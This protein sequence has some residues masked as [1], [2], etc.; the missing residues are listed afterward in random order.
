MPAHSII[1]LFYE[2]M[3]IK[4]IFKF[5]ISIIVFS[6]MAAITPVDAMAGNAK[7]HHRVARPQPNGASAPK[8]RTKFV[9]NKRNFTS[10][11]YRDKSHKIV[12]SKLA[13]KPN[14][15]QIG[16]ESLHFCPVHGRIMK[17][18]FCKMKQMKHASANGPDTA[19][20]KIEECYISTD[21][22]GH[23]S[24][25]VAEVLQLE[26]KFDVFTLPDMILILPD[27]I[28]ICS[29]LKIYSHSHFNI[30]DKPPEYST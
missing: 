9:L 8:L 12:F 27:C 29:D 4:L 7:D 19:H 23:P 22:L 15:S 17:G 2:S 21:D 26:Y 30:P 10:L 24:G 14:N 20:E 1:L 16:N 28:F 13:I 18:A 6:I 5:L 3:N 25:T 11:Q